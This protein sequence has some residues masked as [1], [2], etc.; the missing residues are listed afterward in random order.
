MVVFSFTFFIYETRFRFGVYGSG[1]R[2]G[3]MVV[4][5][6]SRTKALAEKLYGKG[7]SSK[8]DVLQMSKNDVQQVKEARA[9]NAAQTRCAKKDLFKPV[10]DK[11]QARRPA[12]PSYA[13]P[14]GTVGV[15]TRLESLTLRLER[16]SARL[17]PRQ[18]LANL[19]GDPFVLR[20]AHPDGDSHTHPHTRTHPS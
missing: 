16:A 9:Q 12:Q 1:L 3:G 17:S 8:D 2:V 11:E 10:D 6:A 7:L 19:R 14:M 5:Q 13:Y 20:R 18:G 15:E 4:V